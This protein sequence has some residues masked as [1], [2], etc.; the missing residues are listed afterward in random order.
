MWSYLRTCKAHQNK[1]VSQNSICI[2]R[3]IAMA[4]KREGTRPQNTSE[5]LG[6]RQD[7]PPKDKGLKPKDPKNEGTKPQGSS[8]YLAPNGQTR[9]GNN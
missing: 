4:P 7:P 3:S 1:I 2:A 5:Y 8:E 6:G 9:N